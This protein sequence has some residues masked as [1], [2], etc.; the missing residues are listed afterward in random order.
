M[1][2]K[3]HVCQIAG[4]IYK[5]AASL[6]LDITA[7]FPIGVRQTSRR[8]AVKVVNGYIL[9]WKQLIFFQ[10]VCFFLDLFCNRVRHGIASLLGVLMGCAHWAMSQLGSTGLQSTRLFHCAQ[11]TKAEQQLD[12]LYSNVSKLAIPAK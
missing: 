6:V 4:V 5:D 9:T 2:L 1:G 10:G 8:V 12:L 3:L 7:L 11:N